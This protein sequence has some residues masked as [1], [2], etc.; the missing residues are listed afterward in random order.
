MKNVINT[1]G[2]TC[3][4]GTAIIVAVKVYCLAVRL[5]SYLTRNGY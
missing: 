1:I 4:V 3:I 5:D 2:N